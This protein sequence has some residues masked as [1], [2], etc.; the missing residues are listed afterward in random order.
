MKAFL[1]PVLSSTPPTPKNNVY[2]G[3]HTLS[4]WRLWTPNI[5]SVAILFFWPPVELHLIND[6]TRTYSRFKSPSV[7][8]GRSR[9]PCCNVCEQ[10]PVLSC[11]GSAAYSLSCATW[12]PLWII[13][14]PG[15]EPKGGKNSA[16]LKWQDKPAITMS[17]SLHGLRKKF[18]WCQSCTNGQR[19]PET[20]S[21]W[22]RYRV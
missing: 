19:P 1:W 18:H 22:N 6:A 7:V 20:F 21:P 16:K 4:S 15:A 8:L 13:W 11:R 2:S 14:P 12:Q 5:F 10:T 9:S 3:S 17:L